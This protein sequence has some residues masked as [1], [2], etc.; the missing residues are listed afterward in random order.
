MK[1]TILRKWRLMFIQQLLFI[2]IKSSECVKPEDLRSLETLSRDF[3]RCESVCFSRDLYA[4]QFGN[5]LVLPFI[6]HSKNTIPNFL[7]RTYA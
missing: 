7:N 3:G 5:I 6:Q 2:E 4:K 1:L